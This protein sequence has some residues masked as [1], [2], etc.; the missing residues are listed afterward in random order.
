MNTFDHCLSPTRLLSSLLDTSLFRLEIH[1][2][3][4][5]ITKWLWWM[6]IIHLERKKLH[7]Q[8]LIS[9]ALC[10]LF[11]L[12]LPKYWYR[13]I[14]R[15]QYQM[16]VNVPDLAMGWRQLKSSETGRV[17]EERWNHLSVYD[18]HC[19]AAERETFRKGGAGCAFRHY[20]RWE[21]HLEQLQDMWIGSFPNMGSKSSSSVV[22]DRF[23]V[24]SKRLNLIAFR[25]KKKLFDPVY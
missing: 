20:F 6:W 19:I 5:E 23:R 7:N 18:C 12:N 17:E 3:S 11:W 4:L 9:P 21:P 8:L 24:W 1:R 16:G 2:T 22:H 10:F 25:G 15:K 13:L 14:A